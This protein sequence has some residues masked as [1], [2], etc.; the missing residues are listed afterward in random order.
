[1]RAELGDVAPLRAKDDPASK[2]PGVATR[3][4]DML[5]YPP[6][7]PALI[8]ADYD[9]KGMPDAV[10]ARVVALGGFVGALTS[11]LPPLADA[12]Y[13]RR[14]ST[15]AGLYNKET[16]ERYPGGHGEHVYLLAADGADAKRF[17][18]ALHDR[19][20][21]AGLG[22]YIVSKSGALLERIDRR[23]HG[24]RRRAP[25]LRGQPYA[26]RALGAGAASGDRPRRRPARHAERPVPISTPPNRPPSTSSRDARRARS[27]R[28][29]LRRANNSSRP[30]SP[31]KSRAACRPRRRATSPSSGAR[32]C[33]CQARRWSST[34]RRSAPR[35]SATCSPTPNASS[36]R[37]W[38]TRSK[39]S[40]MGAT[41][42]SCCATMSAATSSSTPS[43]MA[44]PTT[45]LRHDK[46]SIAAAVAAADK[47]NAAQVFCR[48]MT[49]GGVD[50]GLD[51]VETKALIKKVAARSGA[52]VRDIAQMLK[53]ARREIA[54]ASGASQA[55]GREPPPALGRYCSRRRPTRRSNRK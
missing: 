55:Q 41:A 11:L 31:R 54:R 5:A 9:T 39:A 34:I 2:Q 44:A 27:T 29:A 21:L 12:A 35:P 7:R 33:C 13:V 8:L 49:Q 15:S 10:R 3:T 46:D 32:A 23:P 30:G 47:A 50:G 37:R 51:P 1:M 40:T 17:L 19:A 28:N 43:R 22:W 48:L 26:G 36:T 14:L 53:G 42:P 6:G 45:R 24:R 38:P 4:A 16:G 52:G 18:Y 25:G 20:W